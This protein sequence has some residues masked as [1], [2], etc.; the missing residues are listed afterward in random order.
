MEVEAGGEA[1]AR[2]TVCRRNEEKTA[3]QRRMLIEEKWNQREKGEK[4]MQNVE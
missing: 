2:A 3:P 4:E 1:C